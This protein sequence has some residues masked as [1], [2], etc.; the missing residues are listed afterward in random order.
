SG[1]GTDMGRL[2]RN[3]FNMPTATAPAAPAWPEPATAARNA[4][5]FSFHAIAAA[6][7]GCGT[8][9]GEAASRKPSPGS[10]RPVPDRLSMLSVQATELPSL[11]KVTKLVEAGSDGNGASCRSDA[12]SRPC[13]STPPARQ[14][15]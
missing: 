1:T 10:T 12:S 15:A 7:N 6:Y 9:L 14:R 3:A 13:A 2:V 11:S 8:T 4:W 5:V